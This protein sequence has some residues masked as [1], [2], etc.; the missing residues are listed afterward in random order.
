MAQRLIREGRTGNATDE[1]GPQ[2]K[3]RVGRA[4]DGSG[5]DRSAAPGRGKAGAGVGASWADWAER[6]R[7]GG[8]VGL[9]YVFLLF[10][11]F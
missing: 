8:G 6:P 1:M 3:E 11:N 10:S 2:R 9:L 7:E 5:A 4:R